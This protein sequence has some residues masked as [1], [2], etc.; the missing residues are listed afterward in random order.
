MRKTTHIDHNVK[1]ALMNSLSDK[2][3]RRRLTRLL[4]YSY[5]TDKITQKQHQ[6]VLKRVEETSV[7]LVEFEE[8]CSCIDDYIG[9]YNTYRLQ[10]TLNKMT[11]TNSGAIS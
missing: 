3:S 9:L 1:I 11:P 10:W 2:A 7:S 6:E 5:F 4:M 8:L